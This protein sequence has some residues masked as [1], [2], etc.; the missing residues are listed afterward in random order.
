ML[1]AHIMAELALISLRE[2]NTKINGGGGKLFLIDF[3][4]SRA[5]L[6]VWLFSLTLMKYSENVIDLVA[7]LFFLCPGRSI[8]LQLVSIFIPLSCPLF[9]HA[10]VFNY[11]I[12][13]VN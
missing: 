1:T 3:V 13:H 8:G 7:G 2:M 6:M 9:T 11:R 4:I 5:A 12:S 10:I